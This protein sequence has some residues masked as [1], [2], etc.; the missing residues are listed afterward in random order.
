MSDSTDA[1]DAALPVADENRPADDSADRP[2]SAPE[3]EAEGRPLSKLYEMCIR[4]RDYRETFEL[5]MF[6]EPVPVI[7][8]PL[9]DETF[10]PIVAFL[11]NH[12]GIETD[13]ETVEAVEEA[14]EEARDEESGGIDVS[15][16][17]AEVVAALQQA[18]IAGID[19]EAMGH[20]PAEIEEM[21]SM[22]VGGYSVEI[23]AKVL[24]VSGSIRDATKFRGSRGGQRGLGAE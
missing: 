6:G 15:K 19:A 2:A 10:I 21:V 24:D 22:M 20:T 7:L 17:D 3:A 16:L 1:T 18:A 23:G 4:G 14:V 9:V 13:E 8:R 5:E 11:R 12:L